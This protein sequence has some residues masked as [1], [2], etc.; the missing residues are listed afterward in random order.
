M[1]QAIFEDISYPSGITGEPPSSFT[2]GVLEPN[3]AI[4]GPVAG[5]MG[6]ETFAGIRDEDGLLLLDAFG[7][8]FADV[9]DDCPSDS[10]TGSF[11]PRSFPRLATPTP[12]VN[13]VL[14]PEHSRPRSRHW[15]QYGRRRSHRAPRL[16]QAKQSSG[17]P[18]TTV[19]LRRFRIGAFGSV[20]RDLPLGA[21]SRGGR[22]ALSAVILDWRGQCPHGVHQLRPGRL[23]DWRNRLSRGGII[24][25]RDL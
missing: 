19:L 8:D 10:M 1:T 16:E 11:C 23:V 5:G 3:D 9:F 24:W 2:S 22:S 21:G 25:R 15:E 14:Y 4:V 13:V 17:A 12:H 7:K 6:A 20:L 18:L